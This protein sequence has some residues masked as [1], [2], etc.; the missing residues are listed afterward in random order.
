[1]SVAGGL[2]RAVQRG[3]VHG[4]DAI[5]IFAKNAN[6]WRG[7]QLPP[8]EIRAFRLLVKESGITPVVSHAS[9][10]INLASAH[11]GLRAQSMEAMGDEL[12]R[13]ERSGCSASSSIR[14]ATPMAA[15][16]TASR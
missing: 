12:D 14:A 8:E 7:R 4:C 10:L 16:R 5:Q 9:Y 15:R 6:Q 11:R 1:M 13:A 3:V 2:P